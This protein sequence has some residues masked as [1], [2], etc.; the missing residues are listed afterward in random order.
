MATEQR[1]MVGAQPGGP[2]RD[3][4]PATHRQELPGD[5][6]I[7]V[8]LEI[9]RASERD[10]P[11]GG[12]SNTHATGTV[13]LTGSR[14]HVSLAFEGE[15]SVSVHTASM[16]DTCACSLFCGTGVTPADLRVEDGSLVVGAYVSDRER[17]RG[18]VDFLREQ[19]ED[20]RLRRLTTPER[21]RALDGWVGQQVYDEVPVT[22]KQREAV[23]A[24]VEMGYYAEPREANLDDLANKLGVSTSA[25]SQRLNAVESKL[26]ESLAAEL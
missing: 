6:K 8:E 25:L 18:I 4:P 24:A 10:C 3:E 19:V 7:W 20:W 5:P 11:I 9:D 15:D 2:D 17:L 22:D 14:C 16:D 26:V 13:Q 12:L 1:Y 23:E 21:N